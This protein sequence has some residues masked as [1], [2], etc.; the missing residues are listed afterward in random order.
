MDLAETE[1]VVRHIT[2]ETFV[3]RFPRQ[4]PKLRAMS[5]TSD[6]CLNRPGARCGKCSVSTAAETQYAVDHCTMVVM[7]LVCAGFT[8]AKCGVF[9]PGVTCSVTCW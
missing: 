3:I 4:P 7:S 8:T 2:T 1:G 9:S 6:I 5:D